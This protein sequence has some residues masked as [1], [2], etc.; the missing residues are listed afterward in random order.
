MALA[1]PSTSGAGCGWRSTC[2]GSLGPLV[3][4]A[5]LANELDIGLFDALL[6]SLVTVGYVSLGSALFALAW[7]AGASQLAALAAGRYSP[8]AGGSSSP[9]RAR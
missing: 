5:V 1:P 6:A 8:Y 2:S 3:G 4:L 7:L 9:P